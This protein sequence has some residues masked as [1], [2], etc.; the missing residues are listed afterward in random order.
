[1]GVN[2]QISW[3]DIDSLYL[4][5]TCHFPPEFHGVFRDIHSRILIPA[6]FV[7]STSTKR[8]L[9][10]LLSNDRLPA[11]FE[12]NG[13]LRTVSVDRLGERPL[14]VR[15]V[16]EALSASPP[17]FLDIQLTFTIDLAANIMTCNIGSTMWQKIQFMA[18][19]YKV[20]Q[21]AHHGIDVQVPFSIGFLT[22]TPGPTPRSPTSPPSP[23]PSLFPSTVYSTSHP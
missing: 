5:P 19:H 8:L 13:E 20:L 10:R 23:T 1:M 22:T 12:S 21:A 11:T 15:T 4:R 14:A 7:P 2:L 3:G 6:R 18:A 17:H 16:G 9:R